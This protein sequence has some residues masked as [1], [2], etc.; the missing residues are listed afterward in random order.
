MRLLP[1][2][3]LSIIAFELLARGTGHLFNSERYMMAKF[4]TY[5]V[6]L[7]ALVHKRP[8]KFNVTPKG[9]S[10]VPFR[11]YA[12][13]AL[14]LVVSV[15]AVIW[16]PLAHSF[17]WVTYRTND[18]ALAFT[19][20]ALWAGWNVYFATYVVRLSLRMK[21]QRAD[22][23][24]LENLTVRLRLLAE[25][26]QVEQLASIHNL[27]PLGMAFRSTSSFEP[28]TR[29]VFTLPLSSRKIQAEGKVIHV[30]TVQAA[31]GRFYHHGV[32]FEGMS[33]EDRD[34]IELHCTQD[35][36]PS[37]RKRYRQSLDLFSR[38]SELMHNTRSKRRQTVQLPAY[39]STDGNGSDSATH[40][41]GLLEELSPTGARLLMDSPIPPGT[42]ISFEVPGTTLKGEGKVV[43]VH[44]L[45]SPMS[46]RFSVGLS[47]KTQTVER[48]RRWNVLSGWSRA[49]AIQP[50]VIAEE[51]EVAEQ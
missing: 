31:H 35:S 21:Q 38:T 29:L 23:R 11:A 25:G 24:F 8:L 6:S 5:I 36:V 7:A 17:G 4:S 40:I 39:V 45:E 46:V 41:G 3:I 18:F 43:F 1:Y 20:S 48:R 42:S 32:Q 47:L 13:Q 28:G 50:G 14:V 34:A 9:T 51:V 49:P 15:I 33:V 10:D 19:A 44:A 22:H 30:E 26:P 27:N 12:P 37:W 2:L 16:A